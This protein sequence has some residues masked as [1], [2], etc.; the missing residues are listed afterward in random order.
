MAI[1]WAVTFGHILIS[2][3]Q[4][5]QQ[6]RVQYKSSNCLELYFY[7]GVIGYT[8]S[9]DVIT[10]WNTDILETVHNYFWCIKLIFAQERNSIKHW[11]L[12]DHNNSVPWGRIWVEM[13]VFGCRGACPGGGRLIKD[14][15]LSPGPG[16][17]GRT[18]M[19]FSSAI[20]DNLHIS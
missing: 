5:L 3:Q 13:G 9:I 19:A 6:I 11:Q 12:G 8:L 18:W 2:L 15:Q 1:F 14:S 10:K 4:E 7:A 20:D 16:K 17:L